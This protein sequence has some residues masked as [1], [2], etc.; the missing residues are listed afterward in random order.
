MLQMKTGP[1]YSGL[2]L[3]EGIHW[4]INPDVN[5]EYISDNDKR[6]NITYV[7]YTNKSTGEVTVYRNE[8]NA[9][10][11]SLTASST[12]RTMDCIDCHN[13]PS[14]NYN[15]PTVYFDKAMLT[16]AVSKNIP[17]FKKTAMGILR[18]TFSN[19][20][21]AL[22]KIEQSITDYYKSDY[23]EFYANNK[24][25]INNSVVSVK[26]AFSQNTFPEMKVSYDFYPEHIGHLESDGCFRCHNDAFKSDN[27]RKI[28]KDCNL[29]HTIVGQGKQGMM[30]FTN[31]K[32]TLE[33][34]HPVDIGT[35]WKEANCSECHKYLY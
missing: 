24:D 19:R 8:N 6:E 11:D 13:R 18:E 30:E 5:I 15:S 2:G 9:I 4:H 7:K 25:L 10:S 31:I 26:E 14:H 33:F 23:N 3:R 35:A 12:T 28:T 27:G 34:R 1:E 20:D 29:C 16:G 17:F 22:L 21:T 32:E